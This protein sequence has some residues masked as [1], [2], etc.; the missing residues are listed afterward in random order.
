MYII[1]AICLVK[2]HSMIHD[3]EIILV[4][5]E[6]YSMQYLQYK[7]NYMY[8]TQLY[9]KYKTLRDKIAVTQ[10]QFRE[11][12]MLYTRNRCIWILLMPE[13]FCADS[14]N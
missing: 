11:F 7:Y 3:F 8:K 5:E 1:F 12:E 2:V 9:I 10:C 13:I 6:I 14:K 4:I